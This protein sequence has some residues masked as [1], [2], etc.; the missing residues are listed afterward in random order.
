MML[1]SSWSLEQANKASP[2]VTDATVLTNFTTPVEDVLGSLADALVENLMTSSAHQLRKTFEA[3]QRSRVEQEEREKANVVSHHLSAIEYRITEEV[4]TALAPVL[5]HLHLSKV[6]AEFADV[7]RQ[8]LP[9]FEGDAVS[10][11]APAEV[12]KML[13][14]TLRKLSVAAEITVGATPQ[15]EVV[16]EKTTLRAELGQWCE[17][18]RG[19]AGS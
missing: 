5:S 18:L 3:M 19:L 11:R 6:T 8:A 16:G 1:F 13:S 14:E 15:I 9:E 2:A 4:T 7:L 10:I 12:H 17:N